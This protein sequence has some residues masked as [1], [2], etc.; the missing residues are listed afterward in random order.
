[1][2]P[3]RCY[4]ST[5]PAPPSPRP[6]QQ[7]APEQRSSRRPQCPDT[8]AA[9]EQKKSLIS[10]V[11]PFKLSQ[12]GPIDIGIRDPARGV[13]AARR[14][15]KG[16]VLDSRYKPTASRVTALIVALPIS[17]YLSYELIQRR[18]MGKERKRHVPPPAKPPE[19]SMNPI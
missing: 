4:S 18:F 10:R 1:M 7:T 15:A 5:K 11:W 17:I 19:G 6:Y 2:P 16:G 3:N 14:V 12:Q 8:P 13:E 9:V